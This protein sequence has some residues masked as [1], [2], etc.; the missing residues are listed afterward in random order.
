MTLISALTSIHSVTSHT[1][2][3]TVL[4]YHS[5][6]LKFLSRIILIDPTH[7]HDESN[8]SSSFRDNKIN[9]PNKAFLK[10]KGTPSSS[11]LNKT[12]ICTMTL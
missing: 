2:Y 10:H 11:I 9:C 3:R 7:L 8:L 1:L 4:K 6:I 5:F 12:N